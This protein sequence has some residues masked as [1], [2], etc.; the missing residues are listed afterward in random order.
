MYSRVSPPLARRTVS[1]SARSPGRNRAS[2]IL[3]KRPA[4]H[5]ADARGLD[6]EGA[7]TPARE[8]LVPGEH[9]RR[10]EAV[11]GRTPGHHRRNPGALSEL[12]CAHANRLKQRRA[13][14]LRRGRPAARPGVVADA[15]RRSPHGHAQISRRTLG[16]SGSTAVASISTL[17][18]RLHE[19]GD[20]HHRHRREVPTHHVPVHRADLRELVEVVLAAG[21]VPG[22]PYD[23]LG[24]PPGLLENPY[25]VLQSHAHLRRETLVGEFLLRVPADLPGDEHLRAARG[26]PVRIALRAR[27][28]RGLQYFVGHRSTSRPMMSFWTSV[29]PS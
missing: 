18:C 15:L 25:H 6:H 1:T 17:A 11:L 2:P 4:R 13:R 22:E 14:G 9:V 23:V 3:S 19:R 10:D 7:G 26:D 29:A 8:T 5:V 21:Q 27:P 24:P 28:F 16:G 20:L 12:V